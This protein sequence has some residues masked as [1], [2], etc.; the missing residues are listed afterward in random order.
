MK[1]NEQLNEFSKD[2]IQT[3]K[4]QVRKGNRIIYT[5]LRSVSRSGMMRKIDVYMMIDNQPLYLNALIEDIGLYKRDRQTWALK[6]P[7]CG[8]DMGF[9][10]VYNLSSFL[11]S[12]AEEIVSLKI[13]G[14][15]GE[16][17][18]KTDG[19]YVLEQWWL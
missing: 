1:T 3:I 5:N 8:M 14:R 9:S 2:T 11:Y 10:V 12:D 6:V 19:G 4:E 7:G 17:F 15:N 13:P 18:E 16:Q